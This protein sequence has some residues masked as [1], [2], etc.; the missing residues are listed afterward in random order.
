MQGLQE[1][2]ELLGVTE[3][4]GA[5][6]PP[7]ALRVQRQAVDSNA[8]TAPIDL[9]ALDP[10]TRDLAELPNIPRPESSV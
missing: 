3:S 7:D 4:I 9:N 1:V 6:K 2:E 10:S 5:R 8:R